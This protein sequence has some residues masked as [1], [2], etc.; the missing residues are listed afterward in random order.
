[1]QG[2]SRVETILACLRYQKK[3]VKFS[4]EVK[5]WGT[6]GELQLDSFIWTQKTQ[7]SS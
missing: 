7:K 1:M 6:Q 4:G 3:C 5:N 2:L